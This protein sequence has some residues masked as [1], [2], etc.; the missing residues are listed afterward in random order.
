[1]II[2][3]MYYTATQFKGVSSVVSIQQKVPSMFTLHIN[4]FYKSI[5]KFIILSLDI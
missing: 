1:M 4:P 3:F 5:M 2:S